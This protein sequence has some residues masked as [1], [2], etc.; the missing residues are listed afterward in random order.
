M[1]TFKQKERKKKR[2]KK[3]KKKVKKDLLCSSF[4]SIWVLGYISGAAQIYV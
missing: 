3:E 2:K 4:K 1:Y